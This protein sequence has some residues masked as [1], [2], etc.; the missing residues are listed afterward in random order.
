MDIPKY[1]PS[2]PFGSQEF[3]FTGFSFMMALVPGFTRGVLLKSKFPSNVICDESFG[4][5]LAGLNRFNVIWVC[6]RRRQHWC[7]GNI[8]PTPHSHAMKWFF[9]VWMACSDAILLCVWGRTNFNSTDCCISKVLSASEA[10]F[11][12]QVVA[13]FNPLLAN[14]SWTFL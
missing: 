4:F 5:D 8:F 9:H 1:H 7:I 6:L 14:S 10:L 11:S 2:T 12:I 13:G 3:C